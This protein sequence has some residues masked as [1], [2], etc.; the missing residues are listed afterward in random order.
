[1]SDNSPSKTSKRSAVLA[2]ILSLLAPG[3]GQVYC[4]RIVRG[5]LFMTLVITAIPLYFQVLTRVS[6]PTTAALLFVVGAYLTTCLIPILDALWM[7]RRTRRDYQLKEYNRLSVYFL[8]WVIMAGSS[9]GYALHARSE[10][11]EAFRVPSASMYPTIVPDDRFLANKTV[12]D[13]A[14]P[15]PGD[16]VIYISPTHRRQK[17]IK[18]VIACAGDTVEIRQGEVWVNDQPLNRKERSDGS[19]DTIAT[20]Y[21]AGPYKGQV[22]DGTIYEE[23]NGGKVYLTLYSGHE[24]SSL[25]DFPRTV[26]PAHHCFVL[27]DN[28]DDSYDSRHHGSIP[29]ATIIGRADY[30][31]CPVKDWSRFGPLE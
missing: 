3:V 16:L 25:A 31:Y 29:L 5:L 15:E 9:L 17:W 22:I 7:A 2:G 27:G 13:T 28:R 18:R 11:V 14:D 23:H 24:G 1:M 19:L 26:I 8:F 4:G 30:L 20:R 10:H 12:Y 6:T 21:T